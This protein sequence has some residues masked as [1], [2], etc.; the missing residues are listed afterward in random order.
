MTIGTLIRFAW[1]PTQLRWTHGDELAAL[2]G[3]VLD[4]ELV[5][6]LRP[7]PRLAVLD[8]PQVPHGDLAEL[9]YHLRR[10][11]VGQLEVTAASGTVRARLTMRRL[12]APTTTTD[13]IVGAVAS[14]DVGA[15]L[16]GLI[17][18]WLADAGLGAMATPVAGFQ[19]D[20]LV[21][22]AEALAGLQREQDRRRAEADAA[23]AAD[24][25]I[26]FEPLLPPEVDALAVAAAWLSRRG[27]AAD[28]VTARVRALDPQDLV[29]RLADAVAARDLAAVEALTV[30]APGWAAPH[31]RAIELHTDKGLR[32]RHATEA[33]SRAPTDPAIVHAAGDALWASFRRA[34]AIRVYDRM[35]WLDRHDLAAHSKA[36]AV[37]AEQGRVGAS[38]ADVLARFARFPDDAR[39]TAF[40]LHPDLAWCRLRFA[41]VLWA[42]GRVHEAI[43][44]RERTLAAVFGN[45]S[46]QTKVLEEWRGGATPRV[47]AYAREGHF[48]G[49]VG[50]A[51]AGAAA[52]TIDTSTVLT[53]FL[54]GLIETGNADLAVLAWHH[55]RNLP[56]GRSVHADLVAARA[57]I[58]TGEV[59]ELPFVLMSAGLR[60]AQS[61][62]GPEVNR[63]LRAAVA[64]GVDAWVAAI[65]REVARGAT[66]L[67]SRLA[68]DAA[69][70]FP[71]AAAHPAL[72]ALASG[73]R[74]PRAVDAAWLAPLQAALG[75]E[76][77]APIDAWFA[78]GIGATA[79][80]ERDDDDDDALAIAD[81][82]VTGWPQL[83]VPPAPGADAAARRHHVG[84]LLYLLGR[85]LVGY[86]AA[87]AGPPSPRAGA[88]RTIA[89][90]VLTAL[91]HG[92]A[93][94][95]EATLG[96][97]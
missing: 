34:E 41:N 26:Q 57:L 50:R 68:R 15:A 47:H 23:R 71:D 82:A 49:D 10:D 20:G 29:L 5:R 67:A 92:R 73:G 24:R 61:D 42:I 21:A 79:G 58:E 56:P 8:V 13:A 69:D 89:D 96:A 35:T 83:V 66:T 60:G 70:Y 32:L 33:L 31:H 94:I 36:M 81:R 97:L 64:V 85:T 55:H 27:A 62:H 46:N 6:A 37:T 28:A 30:A 93:P 76:V 51:V 72:A 4:V 43:D 59:D 18:G 90:D 17:D 77:T 14:A 52:A 16:T 9:C 95:A 2:A 74:A 12:G 39:D 65:D 78:A 7:H 75:A 45:W 80:A 91:D 44:V 54:H 11:V 1:L 3:Q 38:H 87:T 63:V 19:L 53:A 86:L 48:R 22:T 40:A 88:L 25:E 84:Q